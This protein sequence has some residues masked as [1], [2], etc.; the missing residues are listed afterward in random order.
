M[1]DACR[2]QWRAEAIDS[3]AAAEAQAQEA[4][5]ECMCGEGDGMG[6][7]DGGGR[8]RFYVFPKRQE[9]GEKFRYRT[10]DRKHENSDGEDAC[11]G[12]SDGGRTGT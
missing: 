10:V 2:G 1:G 9:A 12:V 11:C 5:A 7:G 3:D 6:C 4:A 8:G